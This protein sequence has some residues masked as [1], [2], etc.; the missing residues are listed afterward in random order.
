[1]S[2]KRYAF[3]IGV[4]KYR[5]FNS[6]DYCNNNVTE[7]KQLLIDKGGFLE[8]NIEVLVS[9][10]EV[11]KS[12]IIKEFSE[13]LW[14]KNLKYNDTLLIYFIGHGAYYQTLYLLSSESIISK[15]YP[16]RIEQTGLGINWFELELGRFDSH[17]WNV[18]MIID[19]CQSSMLKAHD[20]GLDIEYSKEKSKELRDTLPSGLSYFYS[21]TPLHKGFSYKE[22]D[23]FDSIF[24]SALLYQLNKLPQ[25][26]SFG[27]LVN[28]VKYRTNYLSKKFDKPLQY[29][30]ARGDIE[31]YNKTILVGELP[32]RDR[33]AR[34]KSIKPVAWRKHVSESIQRLK[35]QVKEEIPQRRDN[36]LLYAIWDIG[37][38]YG[39]YDQRVERLEESLLYISEV[40]SA[41]D[42]VILPEFSDNEDREITE[43]LGP[44][45]K[46]FS[47]KLNS[48]TSDKERVGVLYNS[49]RIEITDLKN[50]MLPSI[51]SIIKSPP[52][53]ISFVFNEELFELYYIHKSEDFNSDIFESYHWT[54]KI[55]EDIKE[56]RIRYFK[57]LRDILKI[58]LLSTSREKKNIIVDGFALMEEDF[59]MFSSSGFI[60]L[61]GGEE[62]E[63]KYKSDRYISKTFKPL[64]DNFFKSLNNKQFLS[65]Y[66]VFR[67]ED[68][69]LYADRYPEI[70]GDERPTSNKS[71]YGHWFV[72]PYF[73]QWRNYQIPLLL[74]SEI[75]FGDKEEK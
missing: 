5:Y 71:K 6:F 61:H 68:T 27:E 29:P 62:W 9:E 47:I 69:K 25:N 70:K 64:Y 63:K 18:Y 21:C 16:D 2:K 59:D 57:L 32:V 12:D 40:A 53:S 34:L 7:L 74:W 52:L 23:K 51:E 36:N 49:S 20:T 55:K 66:S 19:A 41:F 4:D 10:N 39:W 8:D 13:F 31:A 15:R 75:E 1:M 48:P 58:T 38:D 26:V 30:F 37:I 50:D 46:N 72:D 73:I 17:T 24:S 54:E 35:N 3:L 44:S 67:A 42:M 56:L 11:L 65:H 22:G 14:D 28:K 45:W 33:K 43:V 60:H